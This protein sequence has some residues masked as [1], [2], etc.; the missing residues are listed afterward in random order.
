[1]SLALIN[2]KKLRKEVDSGKSKVEQATQELA[3]LKELGVQKDNKIAD[4]K[5]KQAGI[6][7]TI[8]EIHQMKAAKQQMIT[9]NKQTFQELGSEFTGVHGCT[10]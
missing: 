9:Q 8:T 4:L 2:Q 10:Q 3:H 1:V 5:K 6:K 7:G